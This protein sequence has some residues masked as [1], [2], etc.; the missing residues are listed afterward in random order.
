[1]SA[2]P[3]VTTEKSQEEPKEAP[4]V[5]ETPIEETLSEVAAVVV[6]DEP[7]EAPVVE[8]TPIEKTI[9]EVEPTPAA[10]VEEP[11]AVPVH[12]SV[13]ESVPEVAE[14]EVEAP[15]AEDFIPAVVKKD[16]ARV[17]ES[18]EEPVAAEPTP[19]TVAPASAPEPTPVEAAEEPQVQEEEQISERVSFAEIEGKEVQAPINGVINTQTAAQEEVTD[20]ASAVKDDTPAEPASLQSEEVSREIVPEDSVASEPVAEAAT[21]QESPK[22]SLLTP[23]I[24]AAGAAAAVAAGTAAAVGAA[25]VSHKE[26]EAAS[27]AE[28]KSQEPQPENKDKAVNVVPGT[29]PTEGK[30]SLA[31]SKQLGTDPDAAHAGDDAAKSTR[32]PT[33]ESSSNAADKAVATK[34]DENPRSQ[35][36]NRSVTAVS[37]NHKKHDSWLKTILRAV[38]TNFFGAI[39]SPFRRRG[40]NNQ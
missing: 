14:K 30:S 22:D 9:N 4:V 1:E 10:A 25:S 11:I 3:E 34:G 19:E 8:E 26:P 39:F 35:S 20:A 27:P 16:V 29:W 15:A 38:F 40:G 5:E 32:E 7:K 17:T 21:E 31:T 23:E 12:E 6:A 18:V 2:A 37:L 13:E 24:I 33:A 28:T 36:Q